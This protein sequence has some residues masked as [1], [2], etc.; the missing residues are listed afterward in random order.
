MR[1]F[2]IPVIWEM[3]GV[4]TVKAENL[5]EAKRKAVLS[6]LPLPDGQYIEDSVT[7][8]ED[9]IIQ[10][11]NTESRINEAEFKERLAAAEL[12]ETQGRWRDANDLWSALELD[13][14]IE[15]SK[16]EKEADALWLEMYGD[17][18]PDEIK[19]LASSIRKNSVFTQ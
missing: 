3:Y 9:E 18:T 8:D 17:M 11:L 7:L 16:E 14:G 13:L 6:E 5:E 2:K 10:S 12:A 19:E 15:R 1:E 4:M